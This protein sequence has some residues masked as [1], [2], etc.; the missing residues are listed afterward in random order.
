MVIRCAA[1]LHR[2]VWEVLPGP[3]EPISRPPPQ[4]N[5]PV[6]GRDQNHPADHIAE[7]DR[8]E[9]IEENANPRQMG[10]LLHRLA[11]P[12]EDMRITTH[13]QG[14]GDKIHVLFS[15]PSPKCANLQGLPS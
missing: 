5:K 9:I 6:D 10:E 12:F 8:Q 4:V 7:R 13:E 1:G 2:I 15:I 14:E 3:Y 11:Y